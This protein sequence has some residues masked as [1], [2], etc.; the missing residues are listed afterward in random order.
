MADIELNPIQA[1]TRDLKQAA[2]TLSDHEAR[3]LVDSYY[4]MQDNRKRSDNQLLA[5]TKSGE[6]HVVLNWFSEQTTALEDNLK[7]AL[8]AYS[9]AS[10]VGRWA[11]DQSGIGPVISAGLLAHIDMKIAVTAGK[12]WRFA[13]LDN[14]IKWVGAEGAR[15]LVAGAKK[16]SDS[17]WEAIVWLSKAL[18][19]K[20][21]TMLKLTPITI[22]EAARLVT[23]HGGTPN[24]KIE[25]HSD[26]LL[27][28]L[29]NPAC[30][31]AY[32][33]AYPGVKVKWDALTKI[34]SRRP[35]N[36]SLKVLCWKIGESFKKVCNKEGAIY[37]HMYSQRKEYEN[38]RNLKGENADEAARILKEKRIGKA[39]EA[40]KHLIEGRLPPAQILA[41]SQRYAT[42]MFL[43]HWHAVAYHYHYHKKAPRPY[44]IEHGGHE[45]FIAIPPGGEF[46]GQDSA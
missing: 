8:D 42:K 29:P 36:P 45:G 2:V 22:E 20:P 40:Y 38:E 28:A 39:T 31:L 27:L 35:W 17:D 7:K 30:T 44:M 34:L 23:A 1:L 14:S 19:L 3:F 6:P 12:I 10:P 13:G 21:T 5:L 26:N 16:A 46:P 33:E 9:A 15:A 43:S 24:P 37:G 11:R 18:N 32:A 4:M 41:R 25:Y